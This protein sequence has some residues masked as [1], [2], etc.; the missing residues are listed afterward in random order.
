MTLP[1]ADTVRAVADVIQWLVLAVIV[2][3]LA[4]ALDAGRLS[5]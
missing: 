2:A 3:T 4:L 1:P 5:E